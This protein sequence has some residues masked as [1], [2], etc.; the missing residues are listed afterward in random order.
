MVIEPYKV[1]KP[2]TVAGCNCDI[3]TTT[4]LHS[5]QAF[6]LIL[7]GK[8]KKMPVKKKTK[9]NLTDPVSQPDPA[10]TNNGGK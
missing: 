9:K 7:S 8:V 1:L 4:M 3:G 6:Y 5:R 10:D 2:I